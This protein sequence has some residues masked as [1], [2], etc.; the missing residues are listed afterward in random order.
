MKSQVRPGKKIFKIMSCNIYQTVRR[1]GFAKK[2]IEKIVKVVLKDLGDK[3][4]NVSIH[5]IGEKKIRTINKVYRKND[6]PTDVISFA[7][8]EGKNFPKTQE[9]LGDIFLCIPYIK[10]Q[11]RRASVTYKEELIRILIHGILHLFEYEHSSKAGAK[12]MFKL[13]ERLLKKVL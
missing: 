3:N 10:L 9:D 11:A 2:D 4:A 8:K 7:M 12:K 5:F 6:K 1:L 13:Q